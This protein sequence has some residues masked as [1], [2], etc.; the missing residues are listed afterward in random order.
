VGDLSALQFVGVGDLSLN[1]DWFGRDL[2][3]QSVMG[4]VL[5]QKENCKPFDNR[6]PAV[7]DVAARLHK[8]V[9]ED[10]RSSY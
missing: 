1:E 5:T 7:K 2:Q 8:R 6:T 3:V 9:G 10:A 4:L